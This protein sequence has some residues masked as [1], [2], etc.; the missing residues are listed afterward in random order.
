MNRAEQAQQA[1]LFRNKHRGKRLLVKALGAPIN[2]NVR[3][4]S[5][6]AAELEAIGVARASTASQIALMTMS[7]TR[8]VADELRAPGEFDKLAP[9]VTQADA[10]RPFTGRS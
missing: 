8:Q 5:P 10:Q 1:E 2:I 9:A 7:V 3:A 6:S 4:G